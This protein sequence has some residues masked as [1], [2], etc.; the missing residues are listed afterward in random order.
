MKIEIESLTVTVPWWL[1]IIALTILIR[2]VKPK[3]LLKL[4][5]DWIKDG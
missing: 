3:T 5:K 4:F 2:K 1:V